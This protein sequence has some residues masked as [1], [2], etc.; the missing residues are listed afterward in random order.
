MK[1]LIKR[2]QFYGNQY[3]AKSPAHRKAKHLPYHKMIFWFA[4][5]MIA[6]VGFVGYNSK[7]RLDVTASPLPDNFSWTVHAQEP[8][9]KTHYQIVHESKHAE[10]IDLIWLKE[11]SRGKNNPI[12]SLEN[13]CQLQGK[14]NQ[15]G[16]GGMDLKICYDSFEESVK[17]VEKWLDKRT[18]EALCMYNT[19]VRVSNCEYV[20]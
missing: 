6:V 14:T 8:K 19:G 5:I 15:F 16:Y 11:S 20:K 9:E 17:A 18:A 3:I 1:I 13:Y 2:H 12:G 4:I 10:E 7:H